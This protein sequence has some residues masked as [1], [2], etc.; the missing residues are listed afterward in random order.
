MKSIFVTKVKVYT[1]LTAGL[2]SQTLWEISIL[3]RHQT[4]QLKNVISF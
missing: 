1:K 3:L 2:I 4:G